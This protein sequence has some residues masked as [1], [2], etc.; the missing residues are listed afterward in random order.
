MLQRSNEIH[1]NDP[2]DKNR[3][4]L[5]IDKF[6]ESLTQGNFKNFITLHHT[7]A[8][9]SIPSYTLINQILTNIDSNAKDYNNVVV[10]SS[11]MTVREGLKTRLK[12]VVYFKNE[13][14]V[15]KVLAL[16][17]LEISGHTLKISDDIYSESNSIPK[18]IVCKGLHVETV[19]KLV[20]KLKTFAR[21]DEANI[22]INQRTLNMTVVVEEY[23]GLVPKWVIFNK[24]DQYHR[25]TLTASGYSVE[26]TQK[27]L[28]SKPKMSDLFKNKTDVTNNADTS[29]KFLNNEKVFKSR[30]VVTCYFCGIP[31]HVKKE[32]PNFIAEQKAKKCYICGVKGHVASKCSQTKKLCFL[33][34]GSDHLSWQIDKCRIAQEKTAKKLELKTKIKN[35]QRDFKERAS[36]VN[37]N[38]T[39]KPLVNQSSTIKK[40][41]EVFGSLVDHQLKDIGKIGITSENVEL[42]SKN[43]TNVNG[44]RV[45]QQT[46]INSQNDELS[47]L[48]DQYALNNSQNHNDPP[49]A[50]NSNNNDLNQAMTDAEIFDT[51]STVGDTDGNLQLE[52]ASKI[53]DV[54]KSI[55]DGFFNPD[56]LIG[57]RKSR[58]NSRNLGSKVN[59]KNSYS[60]QQTW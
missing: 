6:R 21:F 7:D 28:A 30:G 57:D 40:P 35:A 26:E 33:C 24:G 48:V 10:A 49:P 13:E 47:P 29:W 2:P 1:K 50:E 23:I 42:N 22:K 25:I 17:G 44:M 9:T 15:N 38:I 53:L 27:L 20:E 18:I 58:N 19:D 37:Q 14:I 11:L 4:I 45:D 52:V 59:F 56:S 46:N 31:G 16:K 12:L 39:S 32:C 8:S 3:N 55:V 36:R 60:E 54:N 43:S 41:N 5:T 34:N 51:S